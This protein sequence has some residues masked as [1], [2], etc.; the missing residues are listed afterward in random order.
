MHLMPTLMERQLDPSAGYL[1]QNA[2][3]ARGIR[4]TH[5]SQHRG[6]PRRDARSTGVKLKDGRIMPAD[7]VVMAVGHPPQRRSGQGAPGSTVESRHHRR[8]P[9]CAPPTRIF[10]RSANASSIGGQSMALSRRSMKWRRFWPRELAG[11]KP[12]AS[13]PSDTLDQAEGH[14]HRPVFGRRFRRRR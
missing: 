5:R 11:E 1:L 6:H 7:L 12:P 2:V 10:S 13:R 9:L 4:G 14:R 8:R 3:D